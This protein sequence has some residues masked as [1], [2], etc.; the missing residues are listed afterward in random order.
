MQNK[1][2][3][4][5][6]MKRADIK[7]MKKSNNFTLLELLIVVAILAII[8]GG[9][10]GSFQNVEENAAQAQAARDIAAVDQAVQTLSAF[11]SSLPDNV[12]SLLQ[13]T[14]GTSATASVIAAGEI[15]AGS[16]TFAS[17][18]DLTGFRL[19]SAIDNRS[20]DAFDGSNAGGGLSGKFTPTVLTA[21]Q[22]SNL[23][24]A[25]LTTIRYIDA[26]LDDNSATTEGTIFKFNGG[27]GGNE[28]ADGDYL[29]DSIDIPQ[30]Y[31]DAPRTG[32]NRNRGRGF[33]QPLNVALQF[34]VWSG[35]NPISPAPDYDNVKVGADPE[36]VLVGFG[37]S[38]N[39]TLVGKNAKF[40]FSSGMPYYA[41]VEQNE[42]NNYVILVDVEQRPAKVVA[43]IDSK[44]DFRA[45]EFAEY[46]DQKL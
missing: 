38:S 15:A 26:G 21:Q 46:L 33:A 29:I 5:L 20:I 44:G 23:D 19:A 24:K 4:M 43:V 31:F 14:L 18:A 17:N 39:C 36:A 42:Y 2:K 7:R 8:A 40:G 32:G 34:A 3:K 25:G 11:D 45:E 22:I 1:L 30:Q 28:V 6:G 9:V 16:T 35:Q 13:A 41:N 10:V 12:D 37:L 27:T